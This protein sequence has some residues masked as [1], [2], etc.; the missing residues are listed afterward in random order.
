MP[1]SSDNPAN[2]LDRRGFLRATAA[3][4]GAA[5]LGVLGASPAEAQRDELPPV[6]A[7]IPYSML[8]TDTQVRIRTDL[9]RV[10]FRGGIKHRVEADPYDPDRSVRLRTLEFKVTGKLPDDN[11][12]EG[13]T[14]TLEQNN[15]D[16]DVQ[17]R[18]RLTQ[19][20][21]PRY[22]MVMVLSFT[23]TI[24]RP[25]SERLVLTTEDPARL[26]ARLT[27]FPPQRDLYELENPVDLVL[28]DTTIVTLR[29]FPVKVSGL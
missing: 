14:I 15:P 9:V 24:D 27:Q 3:M 29:R 16:A 6:G 20:N 28:P 18:L 8:A 22:E 21:P 19:G 17:S 12:T 23:M 25:G 2:G 11:G 7:E 5:A 1:A 10:D 13:G 26:F 4:G